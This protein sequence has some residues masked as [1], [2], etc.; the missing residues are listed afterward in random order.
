MKNPKNYFYPD[1]TNE[2]EIARI[3]YGMATRNGKK[4]KQ[5]DF[6][7]SVSPSMINN[8]VTGRSSNPDLR[9]RIERFTQTWYYE[10]ENEK[11]AL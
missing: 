10:Y 8:V 2:F 1:I 4:L 3:N 9:K 5:K 7:P 6:D 11:G